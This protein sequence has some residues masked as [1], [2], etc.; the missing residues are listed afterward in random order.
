MK[1]NWPY[2]PTWRSHFKAVLLIFCLGVLVY[3]NSFSVPFQFDD[4]RIIDDE[5][6]EL[7][8]Q[9]QLW[10]LGQV[11]I[12]TQITLAANYASHQQEVWGYHAV[13][14]AIHL[15][16]S[17][18]VYALIL[19]LI[20]AGESRW[21]PKW[22]KSRMLALSVAAIFVVHPLQTQAVTYII[23]RYELLGALFALLSIITYVYWRTSQSRRRWALGPLGL[24][25]V[26]GFHA[27][28]TVITTPLV[29]V[30]LEGLIYRRWQ[31]SQLRWLMVLML[32]LA[33]VAI[34]VYPIEY[35]L[36]P[37][38][39]TDGLVLTPQAYLEAQVAALPVYWSLAVAPIGQ[40]IDYPESFTTEQ[41]GTGLILLAIVLALVICRRTNP[42]VRLGLVWTL[43]TP[44]LTNSFI[45][46]EDVVMEHRMYLPLVGI[47]LSFVVLL[48]L[49]LGRIK[50]QDQ[51]TSVLVIIVVGLSYLTVTRNAVWQDSQLLWGQAV[52]IA[53]DKS[54]TWANY[55]MALLEKGL[56]DEAEQAYLTGLSINSTSWHVLN[57]LGVVSASRGDYQQ[58]KIYF[59]QLVDI[60]AD[61]PGLLNALGV[62]EMNLGNYQQAAVYF[63]RLEQLE[64]DYPVLSAN[65]KLL[66]TKMLIE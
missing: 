20:G 25:L 24:W 17:L 22:L 44:L 59:E 60:S 46:I 12:L 2:I 28:E 47:T 5:L 1:R 8:Q 30:A 33:I 43:V 4:V 48:G 49:G 27:K 38:T 54:R 10:R 45:P 9:P 41:F 62:V 32:L 13:N 11:R 55:G 42:W 15:T 39:T 52:Q 21:L 58:A 50:R 31:W 34:Q 64:P 18:L 40:S 51:F 29:L 16:N 23:Q 35:V 6:L 19:Q 37:K 3:A 14:L 61:D 36:M 65:K 26:L 53:P 57:G 7:W 56:V 63:E 66:Q